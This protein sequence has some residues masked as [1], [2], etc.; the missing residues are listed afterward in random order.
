MSSILK[1]MDASKKLNVGDYVQFYND[2]L[3]FI[4]EIVNP[5]LVRIRE[6]RENSI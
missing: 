3:G 6:A 2:K 1:T 5:N 4:D